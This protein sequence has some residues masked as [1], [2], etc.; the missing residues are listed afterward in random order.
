M[1]L[2]FIALWLTGFGV[3]TLYLS[4]QK[5]VAHHYFKLLGWLQL[6]AALY[7]W[8][9]AH[10]NEFGPVYWVIS[11]G[12]TACLFI[13]FNTAAKPNT[14]ALKPS[15]N[16]AIN[17]NQASSILKQVI[18]AGPL[19]GLAS[20]GLVLSLVPILPG[21]KAT[22]LVTAAILLP[23]CWAMAI[24]WACATQKQTQP[25][26]SFIAIIALSNFYF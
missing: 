8:C 26:F 13:G 12:I 7:F 17:W 2:L 23:L 15:Q 11:T 24:Y 19:A 4:W 5:K 3:L 21:D 20:I 10:G 18:V 14:T 1:T 9:S 16:H 22:Q 25:V 6:F